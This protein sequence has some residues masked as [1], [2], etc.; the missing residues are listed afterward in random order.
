MCYCTD[1]QIHFVE[2]IQISEQVALQLPAAAVPTKAEVNAKTFTPHEPMQHLTNINDVYP[3]ANDI[4]FAYGKARWVSPF[5][6]SEGGSAGFVKGTRRY[7]ENMSI[8]LPKPF[9]GGL[10]EALVA[11]DQAKVFCEPTYTTTVVFPIEMDEDD[12]ERF[13]LKDMEDGGYVKHV[14]FQE[15][16]QC[17]LLRQQFPNLFLECTRDLDVLRLKKNA[18]EKY[19][20]KA[21]E[22]AFPMCCKA[23]KEGYWAAYRDGKVII[24][25][26]SDNPKELGV[27]VKILDEVATPNLDSLHDFL[28]VCE[29]LFRRLGCTRGYRWLQ[30]CMMS[31]PDFMATLEDAKKNM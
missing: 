25:Q 13:N 31:M 27:P 22:Q 11:I 26:G 24:S 10:H 19:N 28:C 18:F 16:S 6:T 23:Y 29:G 8:V 20:A 12:E 5:P 7:S 14:R 15:G 1:F 30:D 21:L 4:M 3:L 17:R 2:E 9:S